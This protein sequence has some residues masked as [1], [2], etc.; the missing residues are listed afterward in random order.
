MAAYA[1]YV[2]P[3]SH[4]WLS[5]GLLVVSRCSACGLVVAAS[6]RESALHLAESIHTC[7]VYQNYYRDV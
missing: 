7:P 3:F 2:E 6:P 4:L 1:N 5:G